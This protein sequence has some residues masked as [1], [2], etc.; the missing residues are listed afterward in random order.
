VRKRNT[1]NQKRDKHH[2]SGD[3]PRN[4][5]VKEGFSR[6]NRRPDSDKCSAC[7]KKRWGRKKIREAAVYVPSAAVKVVPKL[8]SQ[9]NEKK[10]NGELQACP[11]MHVA[12]GQPHISGKN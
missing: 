10:R 6:I 3:R 4:S 1:E 9:Q 11:K 12:P 2:K 8:V 7:S 5:D